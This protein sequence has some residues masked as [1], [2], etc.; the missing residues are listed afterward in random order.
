MSFL[1]P[2]LLIP[3]ILVSAS[4]SIFL[5]LMCLTCRY[6]YYR[7]FTGGAAFYLTRIQLKVV[8]VVHYKLAVCRD[9]GFAGLLWGANVAPTPKMCCFMLKII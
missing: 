3:E 9:S 8:C 6:S 4:G 2:S 7:W 5:A 1:A